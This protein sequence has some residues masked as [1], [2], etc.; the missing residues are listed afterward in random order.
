MQSTA[1]W[2]QGLRSVVDNGRGH[3]VTVDLP[4][5]KNG[6]D[7][8]P[9]ALELTFMGLSGCISTIFALIAANSKVEFE[10]LTV[11]LED[12]SPEN[13]KSISSVKAIVRVKSEESERK[14]QKVLD[15]TKATCPVE[16][17]FEDAGVDIETT[18]VMED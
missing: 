5:A 14:L 7:Q 8:G 16:L 1:R 3:S 9:T 2:E 10:A 12:T 15:K 4:E 18:L 13:V 11:N 6:T 17:L